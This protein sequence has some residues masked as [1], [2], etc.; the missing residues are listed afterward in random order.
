MELR[1]RDEVQRR[2]LKNASEPAHLRQQ[3]AGDR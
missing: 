3:G 2:I 1:A